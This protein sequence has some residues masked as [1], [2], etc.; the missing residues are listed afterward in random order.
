MD[1]TANPVKRWAVV[2]RVEPG[3]PAEAAGFKAGDVVEKVGDV[4]VKC[5]LDVER[6]YLDLPA[7]AKLDVVARRTKEEVKVAVAVQAAG[8]TVPGVTVAPAGTWSGGGSG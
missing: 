8:R 7:G 6:A 1:P 3:S 5:A 4:P 2:E